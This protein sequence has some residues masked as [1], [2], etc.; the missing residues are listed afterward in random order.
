MVTPNTLSPS[1]DANANA[2]TIA[3]AAATS[4]GVT[5]SGGVGYQSP[6]HSQSPAAQSPYRVTAIRQPG[7]R[8]THTQAHS[9]A[10]TQARPLQ[11]HI[12]F[13]NSTTISNIINSNIHGIGTGSRPFK[14]PLGATGLP[15]NG[16]I[17]LSLPVV[18]SPP[19]L[20]ER[21]RDRD[22]VDVSISTDVSSAAR[23]AVSSRLR[24]LAAASSG[25][26]SSSR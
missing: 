2:A 23:F 25:A 9:Q 20:D 24:G 8:D 17:L 26:V 22:R 7:K 6:L 11:K 4:A 10:Q 15:L 21:D 14:D 18:S 3:G 19:A 13:P 12:S 16:N 1:P 5:F